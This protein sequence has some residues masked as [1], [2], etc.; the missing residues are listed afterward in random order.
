[1]KTKKHYD[2]ERIIYNAEILSMPGAY[3]CFIYECDDPDGFNEI[4]SE[5][6]EFESMLPDGIGILD[7]PN[8]LSG[9]RRTKVFGKAS[10]SSTG[11]H[12]ILRKED[13]DRVLFDNEAIALSAGFRPCAKCLP[14]SYIEWKKR[15][16]I[17]NGKN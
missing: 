8:V 4:E 11:G 7:L 10:C 15:K 13:C 6:I 1:M 2:I 9:N 16:E 14:E 12:L 17:E 5:L 3:E